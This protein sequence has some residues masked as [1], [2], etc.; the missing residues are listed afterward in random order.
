MK[1]K[2]TGHWSRIQC[3][4]AALMVATLVLGACQQSSSEFEADAAAIA[5]NN[6]GVALMGRFDYESAEAVFAELAG[7]NPAW[8]DARINLAIATLNRQREGDEV[9]AL[10]MVQ[11][12]LA[13]EPD[14][15]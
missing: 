10:D 6:R 14:N 2:Y 8:T 3:W 7:A 13:G 9:K 5:E 11:A 12:V 15:L 4:R 1:T